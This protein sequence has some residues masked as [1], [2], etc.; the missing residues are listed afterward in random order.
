MPRISDAHAVCP[1]DGF[2]KRFVTYK[3]L[4][5]TD[6]VPVGACAEAGGGVAMDAVA[7]GAGGQRCWVSR[8]V[9]RERRPRCFWTLALR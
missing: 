1:L 7:I 4:P 9:T 8:D 3:R 6:S 5:R 2:A